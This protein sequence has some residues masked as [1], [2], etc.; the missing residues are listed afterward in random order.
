MELSDC[1]SLYLYESDYIEPKILAIDLLHLESSRIFDRKH[2]WNPG[3]S[4]FINV[5]GGF[6]TVTPGVP[7]WSSTEDVP[8]GFSDVKLYSVVKKMYFSK[9][10]FDYHDGELV[11]KGSLPNEDASQ[12]KQ[13]I[14]HHRL[15]FK[16][17]K[18]LW[19]NEIES[20]KILSKKSLCNRLNITLETKNSLDIFEYNTDGNINLFVRMQ[21]NAD[22]IIFNANLSPE[23]QNIPA[24]RASEYM[25]QLSEDM[26]R[27][28]KRLN[29]IE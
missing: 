28:L 21:D 27:R 8:T 7:G 16:N 17:G 2:K 18:K 29:Y 25:Q 10:N 6:G 13:W 22:I 3:S 9:K 19:D 24:S 15:D 4:G 1:K 20:N 12:I 26:R 14:M 5:V 11:F 23:L